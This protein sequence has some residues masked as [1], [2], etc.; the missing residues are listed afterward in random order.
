ME[1]KIDIK[2]III[3]ALALLLIIGGFVLN[4]QNNSI[5]KLNDVVKQE[6]ID[7][8]LQQTTDSIKYKQLESKVFSD[9]LAIAKKYREKELEL[10][11]KSTQKKI[12]KYE[13]IIEVLPDTPN[14][15]RDSIWKS[16]LAKPEQ[17]I[18]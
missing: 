7:D 11:K 8:S 10:F 4:Y 16:E 1:I 2:M 12:I 3:I 13:K 14:S 15:V 9:S 6:Q 18:K 5:R 17:R